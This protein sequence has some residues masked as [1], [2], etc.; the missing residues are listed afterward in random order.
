MTLFSDIDDTLYP[1]SF[2]LNKLIGQNIIAYIIQKLGIQKEKASDLSL[3]LYKHYGTTLAGLR[4]IGYDIDYEDFHGFVHGQLAYSDLLKPDPILRS[5]LLSLPIRKIA[6]TNADAAHASNVL[7][8]LGLEDCFE[9][10]IC[11]ETLNPNQNVSGVVNNASDLAKVLPTGS[12]DIFDIMGEN[13]VSSEY[14]KTP[15][16]CKPSIEA[17]ELVFNM[18]D[19]NPQ[20]TLFFD[21][22]VCNIQSGKRVGLHT[23]LV[24]KSQK[25][26]GADYAL[27]SIHN[28]REALPELWEALE[29]TEKV[30]YTEQVAVETSVRA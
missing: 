1:S 2:G 27:E 18:A 26:K 23:V 12:Q 9:T 16:V 5:L 7:S 20:R 21:D 11:F 29:K 8:R 6:F 14:P 3:L 30:K 28:I 15:V 25:V 10:V 22:S 13:V 24:G 4:A 19:I 17:F